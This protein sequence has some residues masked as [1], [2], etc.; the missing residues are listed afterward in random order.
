MSSPRKTVLELI[1]FTAKS[2]HVEMYF[3]VFNHTYFE[4]KE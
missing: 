1:L 3:V 4:T 2:H